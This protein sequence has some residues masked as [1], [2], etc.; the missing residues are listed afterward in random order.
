MFY[1]NI[2]FILNNFQCVF[3]KIMSNKIVYYFLLGRHVLNFVIKYNIIH[4]FILELVDLYYLMFCDF[5]LV[6]ECFWLH[7]LSFQPFRSVLDSD[8][9][10][11]FSSFGKLVECKLQ[12]NKEGKSSGY[13]FIGYVCL[14]F[15]T[16]FTWIFYE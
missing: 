7:C 3:S 1:F 12:M 10:S 16:S 8:L 9:R 2:L 14:T 6:K 15:Y 5:N 11:A 13:A 4:V